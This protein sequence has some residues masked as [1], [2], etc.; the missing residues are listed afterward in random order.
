MTVL[1]VLISTDP[2][3]GAT[4]SFLTLLQAVLKA[5]VNAIVVVPDTNGIYDTLREMGVKVI[6]V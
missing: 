1:Y 3:G 5:G 6:V 4:K 2:F